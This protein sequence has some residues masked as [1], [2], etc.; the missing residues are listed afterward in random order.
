MIDSLKIQGFRSFDEFS[1]TGFS[2]VNLLLGTN[3]AGK[4]SALEALEILVERANPSSVLRSCV[5]R[6]EFVFD[7][8]SDRVPPPLDIRHLFHGHLVE[9]GNEF[10]ISEKGELKPPYV[11]VL[12]YS[13]SIHGQLISTGNGEF[14]PP[15]IILEVESDLIEDPITIGPSTWRRDRRRGGPPYHREMRIH[16]DSISQFVAT[17]DSSLVEL[18]S[19][20]SDIA[21]ED[22]EQRVIEALNVIE[23]EI[24]RIAFLPGFR[25]VET[26]FAGFFVRMRKSGGRIPIGSL[27]D[28]LKRLLTLSLHLVSAQNGVLLIDEID[29]GL[30]HSV[31]QRMWHLILET[32]KKL[33][34]QVFATTH[35]LDC[36]RSLAWLCEEQEAFASDVCVHRLEKTRKKS[37]RYGADE[38]ID[39]VAHDIEVR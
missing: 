3:N 16:G 36:V 7:E 17:F 33:N 34:I 30:H 32:S 5:R 19:L 11:R 29:T 28:G 24:S 2:N 21:L 31:L 12:P 39:A 26:G 25:R 1:M 38:L 23:P 13:E 14:S 22:D 27:G 35:S 18:S 9:E 6:G 8:Q 20:W 10:A 37:I 15:D 4:T